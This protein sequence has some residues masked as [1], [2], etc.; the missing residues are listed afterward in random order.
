MSA[1]FV[2]ELNVKDANALKEY[3]AQTPAILKEFGGEL[4]MKGKPLLMHA[5]KDNPAPF[6]T[7]VVFKFPTKEQAEGWYNSDAYQALLPIR[8]QAMNSTFRILA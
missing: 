1:L 7:M 4:V 2:I 5:S 3:S 8:D 6:S